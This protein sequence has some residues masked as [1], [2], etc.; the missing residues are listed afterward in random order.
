MNVFDDLQTRVG[1]VI[2]AHGSRRQPTTSAAV[3]SLGRY[4]SSFVTT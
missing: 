3:S 2:T 4:S 1:R